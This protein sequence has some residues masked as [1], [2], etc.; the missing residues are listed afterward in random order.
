MR[1][2]AGQGR[3]GPCRWV[4]KAKGAA[5]DK[6][7][8][9]CDDGDPCTGKEACASGACKAAA[10]LCK[11]KSN[12][13]CE[14]ADDGDLC[15]GT[16]YCDKTLAVADCAFNKAS[17]VLCNKKD[18][19]ACAKARCDPKTGACGLKPEKAG[20]TC[21]DG[22]PCTIKTACAK[23]ACL[24]S[25][26]ACDDSDACTTDTCTKSGGCAHTKRTCEDGN[27]CTSDGCDAKS[28]QC[29]FAKVID[30]RVCNAD[31]DGCTV[32]DACK[33]GVCGVGSP[34][35]CSGNTGPCEQMACANKGPLA[36]QCA[37]VARPDG[38][39]CDDDIS[40][41]AGAVCKAA[42]CLPGKAPRLFDRVYGS[43]SGWSQF[44]DVREQPGGDLL[45]V[46][47]TRSSVGSVKGQKAWLVR[48]DRLGNV[49]KETTV[50][51]S[52]GSAPVA[53]KGVLGGEA[54]TYYIAGDVVGS[55][56]TL[57]TLVQ[58]REDS[59][60]VVWSTTFPSEYAGWKGAG[61]FHDRVHAFAR[62]HQGD[63]A[64]AVSI[65]GPG[66]GWSWQV[67]RLSAKGKILYRTAPGGWQHEVST[68]GLLFLPGGDILLHG[69]RAKP[70]GG[71][72][73]A[74]VRQRFDG[75]G[76][77]VNADAE[78][79][80]PSSTAVGY[81]A[82]V[83]LGGQRL[84][85]AGWN[86]NHALGNDLRQEFRIYDVGGGQSCLRVGAPGVYAMRATH[87]RD[88]R[89]ALVGV[90]KQA[91]GSPGVFLQGLDDVC[92]NEQWSVDHGSKFGQLGEGIKSLA[93][94]GL[95]VT[96]WRYGSASGAKGPRRALLLRTDAWGHGSCGTSGQCVSK[97]WKACADDKECTTD[98]CDKLSGCT[99][100]APA[101]IN[102]SV[103]NGCSLAATCDQG[104]CQQSD[105]GNDLYQR[106]ANGADHRYRINRLLGAYDA[107]AG[108]VRA[109]YHAP[110]TAHMVVAGMSKD[111]LIN[112]IGKTGEDKACMPAAEV[113]RVHRSFGRNHYAGTSKSGSKTFARFCVP[114]AG[115][116]QLRSV[117]QASSVQGRD[118][119]GS[120]EG[121]AW[122]L[123]GAPG[124]NGLARYDKAGKAQWTKVFA[125][126]K[127]AR[128]ES[129]AA[130]AN[131]D[132][133]AAGAIGAPGKRDGLLA[134]VDVAGKLAWQAK[135]DGGADE[136]LSAVRVRHQGD[137][138]F[139]GV[140][141]DNTAVYS[142]FYGA[143]SATGKLMWTRAPAQPDL[144]RLDTIVVMPDDSLAMSGVRELYAEPAV[145]LVR[146]DG[147]GAPLWERTFKGR[148]GDSFLPAR[149]TLSAL[150]DGS[151]FIGASGYIDKGKYRRFW[152]IHTDPLGYA[153]C[154]GP[155]KCLAKV[156][157]GACDDKNP[158][159]IDVCDAA[160]GCEHT[161]SV[162]TVCG[163]DKV[164]TQ[165]KCVAGK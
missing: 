39:A 159:T 146:A 74:R 128:L 32:N 6:G 11:C 97:A 79:T 156:G 76:N 137:V 9:A 124:I 122:G 135:V 140:R 19:T 95:A 84:L 30:G 157:N 86:S 63:L 61:P 80:Y 152:G 18:D 31:N 116:L 143:A 139:T 104:K 3:Q 153:A 105:N 59:G 99:H 42:T 55:S 65:G 154:N 161:P 23:G 98:L 67:A 158:C 126:G 78:Y 103:T 125:L 151:F 92:G 132:A 15:N 109:V 37:K 73:S 50:A 83:L 40:C 136:R 28:G 45:L 57:D 68:R 111:Q 71:G 2:A 14:Q 26:N 58:R 46:G 62:G 107:G 131:A 147:D 121:G 33:S 90:R 117:Q 129:I 100:G 114:V 17:V 25:P 108:V 165:G 102:C 7:P 91:D 85:V 24:G 164:C 115:K 144:G 49:K 138:V 163:K 160:K 96:G 4:A 145:L 60:K 56:G 134:R 70:L 48:T 52:S 130:F 54:G 118:A 16:W 5:G 35:E 8:F 127:D 43:A 119:A 112:D 162:G 110:H 155:G 77:I 106:Y 12:A 38:A 87:A 51:T 81:G 21:D 113:A 120:I 150:P 41:F 29:T 75:K 82:T 141:H 94:G 47:S 142:H 101:G 34:V 20:T 13:D 27:A 44:H 123:F 93:D 64:V 53:L 89:A 149:D 72:K 148:K 36:F 1:R 69:A 66:A 88:R 10:V 22:D 133:A